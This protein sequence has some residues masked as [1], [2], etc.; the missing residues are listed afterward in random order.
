MVK[1]S[2]RNRNISAASSNSQFVVFATIV[3]FLL[4]LTGALLLLYGFIDIVVR[5][6]SLSTAAYLA[7]G[8]MMFKVGQGILNRFAAFKAPP[9]RRRTLQR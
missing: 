8:F 6:D 1:S 2:T 4:F 3:G 5:I 7:L 9:E